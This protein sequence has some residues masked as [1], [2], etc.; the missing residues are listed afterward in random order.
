MTLERGDTLVLYTDGVTDVAPPHDLDDRSVLR[1][2]ERSVAAS[3]DAEGTTD[4]IHAALG[5]ILPLD[6][7]EDDIALLVL[8]AEPTG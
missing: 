3:V 2:V 5:E 1:L 8:R 7:R 4:N 6:R